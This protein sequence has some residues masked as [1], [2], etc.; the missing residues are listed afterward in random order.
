MVR[1]AHK[2]AGPSTV[3][4][5]V[6]GKPTAEKFSTLVTC[7]CMAAV[8][9]SMKIPTVTENR[10]ILFIKNCFIISLTYSKIRRKD[11]IDLKKWKNDNTAVNNEFFY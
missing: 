2:G 1:L 7:A 5:P 8:S 4:H 9:D 3:V 11:G 10:I 6:G